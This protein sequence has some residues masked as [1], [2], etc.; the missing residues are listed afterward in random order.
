M[1]IRQKSLSYDVVVIGGGLAGVCAA[2]ASARHGAK[3]AIVQNRPMFGGNASSEIRMHI[4]GASAHASKKNLSET[5][6]LMEILLEN[7]RRNPHASFSVFD[8]IV[9]EK[10]RWQ[11]NLESFLNTNM[12]DVILRDGE[13]QGVIC[14]Q[15][16]TET[17]LTI[18][19]KVFVDAT[20]HG[21]LGVMAGAASRM[22]SEGKAEFN[23]PNAPDEPNRYLMGN[24]LMFSAIDR[25]EPVPFIK[26]DWAYTFTEDELK[27]RHHDNSC[28]SHQDGGATVE[29]DENANRLPHFSNIDSGY[30]WI[31]LGGDSNDII[32][33]AEDIRDE[34]LKSIY[35]VWD[36]L[37][38]GG[39][40]GAQNLDLDWVGIIPGYR[41]SRRLEGDYLLTENDVRANRVFADAVAYG[42]WAMDEHT[43]GG[44]RDVGKRPSRILNFDGAYTIPYRCYYSRNVKNLMMAG[45][46]ISASKMAFGS[47]RIMGTCAIGGQAV[48]TAAA[49]AVQHGCS[50]RQV[51]Q[52]HIGELQQ[53]LLRDDC[54]I[55]GFVNE[56][57]ADLARS[58]CITATSETDG[59]PAENATN[60]VARTVEKQQN[61]WQSTPLGSKG[62]SISLAFAEP[63]KISQLRITFDPDLTQEIM[64]SIIRMVNQ[65]QIKGMP[66]Q[67]VKDFS[68]CYRLAGEVVKK[69]TITEN[70]MRLRVLEQPEP[71]LCDTIEITALATYGAP[72][73]RIFEIRAY[74]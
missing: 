48:G 39:D 58:A 61:C 57:P 59:C 50:P 20:G 26:P 64:P 10:V 74:A 42:G 30:W 21:T 71:I 18:E 73:A 44:L 19:G 54:Y 46:D 4:V 32:A 65:R 53:A 5:G 55:P 34:L 36:H 38:N 17:Q 43:P 29:F 1:S 25:G 33:D 3:T 68:V 69:Q 47:T 41:E 14:H 11:E 45:R 12:D 15:N 72:C 16:T 28:T 37:K 35:G 8:T 24:S 22:G 56:D 13:I 51:G 6:I 70:A 23:E 9:W 2:I 63:Q 7:K 52:Q 27:Y 67:L 49:L 31:E 62:E 60:G 40:H 66:P